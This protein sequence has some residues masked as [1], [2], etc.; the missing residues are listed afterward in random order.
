MPAVR[1]GASWLLLSHL[2]PPATCQRNSQWRGLDRCRTRSMQ[3]QKMRSYAVLRPDVIPVKCDGLQGFRLAR[4]DRLWYAFSRSERIC[5][6]ARARLR[7]LG[8]PDYGSAANA[9]ISSR[10][11]RAQEAFPDRSDSRFAF[12]MLNHLA[13]IHLELS[14]G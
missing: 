14:E 10:I 4:Q 7:L 12:Q 2:L 9:P 3:A 6:L 5:S 8:T 13:R 11:I 1:W